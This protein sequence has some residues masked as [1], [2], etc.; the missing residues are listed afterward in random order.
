MNSS[1]AVYLRIFLDEDFDRHYQSEESLGRLYATLT[2]LAVFI[3]CLG[4]AGLS[5]FTAEQ[6]TKEIGIRKILGASVPNVVIL[7]VSEFTPI[8]VVPAQKQKATFS[9]LQRISFFRNHRLYR[10][11]HNRCGL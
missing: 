6:R 7:L 2:F 11:E 5:S 1:W 10:S 9:R 3:F 4:L 8:R